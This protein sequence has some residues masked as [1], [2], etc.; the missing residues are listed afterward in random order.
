MQLLGLCQT[1][2]RGRPPKKRDDSLFLPVFSIMSA[3]RA[4]S[5]QGRA[6]KIHRNFIFSLRS[7]N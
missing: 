2:D 5:N 7:I 3:K 6:E 4:G 1:E